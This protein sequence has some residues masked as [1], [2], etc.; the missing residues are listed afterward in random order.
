MKNFRKWDF[1]LGLWGFS[2][3]VCKTIKPSKLVKQHR[4][5]LLANVKEVW[6]SSLQDGMTDLLSLRMQASCFLL[7]Y[8][9]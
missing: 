1:K 3:W 6:M 8:H 5:L 7:L 9:P 4:A 2:W